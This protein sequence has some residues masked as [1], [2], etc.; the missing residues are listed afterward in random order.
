MQETDTIVDNELDPVKH[1]MGTGGHWLFGAFFLYRRAPLLWTVAALVAAVVFLAVMLAVRVFLNPLLGIGAIPAAF[2]ASF[3]LLLPILLGIVAHTAYRADEGIEISLQDFIAVYTHPKLGELLRVALFSLAGILGLAI[4]TSL[5]WIFSTRL[6][7]WTV[8]FAPE[9]GIL[10]AFWPFIL[11]N[12]TLSA[13]LFSAAFYA[14]ALVILRGLSAGEALRLS[15]LG[16]WRNWKPLW[17]LAIQNLFLLAAA[18]LP[19]FVGLLIA[20]PLVVLTF[21]T[22]YSDIYEK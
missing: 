17:W 7:I 5:F 22:S 21:Y 15:A 8:Q 14:P 11:M 12:L 3:S 20:A 9:R 6:G 18:A 2:L 19:A 10:P 1:K 4:L 13:A 16:F